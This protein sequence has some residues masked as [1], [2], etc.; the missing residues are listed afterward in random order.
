MSKAPTERLEALHGALVDAL[1]TRV[2]SGEATTAAGLL[3]NSVHRKA[4]LSACRPRSLLSSK[5]QTC[6]LLF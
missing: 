4:R 3:T 2:K 6:S 1:L 5:S